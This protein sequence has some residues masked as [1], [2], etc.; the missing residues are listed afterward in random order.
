MRGHRSVRSTRVRSP[1]KSA[2]PSASKGVPAAKA[3]KQGTQ[4]ANLPSARPQTPGETWRFRRLPPRPTPLVGRQHEVE[5]TRQKLFCGDVRLLTLTGPPGVGK[6]RLALEV[7]VGLLEEF[8]HGASFVDLA[9]IRD[10]ALVASTIAQTL[11]VF[12]VLDRPMLQQLIDYLGEKQVLLVLDNFEQVIKAGS[13]V[14][15]IL[16]ACPRLK[17]LTTSR[18]PL[19]LH[20]EHEF[21][22]HPLRLPDLAHLPSPE[23]LATYPAVALFV[24]RAQA[25]QP[26]FALSRQ[27]ARAVA[28]ICTRLDGLPLGIE[29]AAARIKLLPPQ[30]IVERLAHQLP[31]PP[32]GVR[33]VPERHQTLQRAITWSYDLLAPS[34]QR[35]FRRLAVFAGGCTLEAAEAVCRDDS[36]PKPDVLEELA[37]L[38]DRSLVWQDPQPDGTPRFRLLESLREFG[39]QQLTLLG[40]M[41]GMQRRH[42]VFFLTLAERACPGLRGPDEKTWLD[43]LESEHENFRA[44][45]DRSF[46]S[47]DVEVGVALAGT[48]AWFW[49]VRGY[50]SEG[51]EWLDRALSRRNEASESARTKALLGAAMLAF[52]QS[53]FPRSFTLAEEGLALSRGMGDKK[54]MIDALITL[55]NIAL[56]KGSYERAKASFAEGLSLAQELSDKGE[57][58]GMLRGLGHVARDQ[59]DYEHATALYTDSLELLRELGYKGGSANLLAWLGYAALSRGE[60]MKAAALGEESLVLSRDLGNKREIAVALN[61]LGHAAFEQRDY[62]RAGALFKEALYLQ[63]ELQNKATIAVSL[64]GIARTADVLQQPERATRLFGAAEALREA[65]GISLHLDDYWTQAVDSIR[66]RL[67]EEAFAAAWAAGRATPLGEVVKEALSLEFQPSASAASPSGESSSPL[68]PRELEVA[69]LVARGLSNREI[70]TALIIGERTVESHVQSILNK[71]GFHT[72]TQIAAWAVARG[73]HRGR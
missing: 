8:E 38:V 16:A 67:G 58:A 21:P 48:L 17:I 50:F 14:D 24:A 28:E 7:A 40:E 43:Q 31:L 60:S 12:E 20:W 62:N 10:P 71:L 53:D 23:E 59:G 11:G 61:L 52:F 13:Q 36:D 70:A 68:S 29:M 22:V 4:G 47:G 64:R 57:I 37:V 19:H 63:W 65:I 3:S 54:G 44:A 72:R 49:F 32:G 34:E 73:L 6:T 41:E 2:G 35:L 15:E 26:S 5:A 9:P 1:R 45:L 18:E 56:V 30:T 66:A 27:N 25:V 42:A 33:N 39:L 69:A 46:Q 55:G 51:R